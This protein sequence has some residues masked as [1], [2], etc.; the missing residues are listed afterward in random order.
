M[1][2]ISYDGGP[3]KGE[4]QQVMLSAI[5]FEIGDMAR[6]LNF[7]RRRIYEIVVVGNATMRD[8]FFGIDVQSV[9]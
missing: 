2:R 5:N 9:G 1:N 8:I 4:L 3:F 6:H 7:H